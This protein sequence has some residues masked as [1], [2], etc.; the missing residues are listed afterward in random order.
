MCVCSLGGGV[1]VCRRYVCGVSALANCASLYALDS[2]GC[3]VVCALCG[4]GGGGG[5]VSMRLMCVDWVMVGC[6]LGGGGGVSV[7]VHWRWWWGVS[8]C[9]HWVVAV[10]VCI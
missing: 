6:A 9:L 2:D 7:C 4:S 1:S 8:V 3:G 5:S 10:A